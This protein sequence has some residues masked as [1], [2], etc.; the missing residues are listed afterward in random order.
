MSRLISTLL[1]SITALQT[2]AAANLQPATP[3]AASASAADTIDGG[4]LY[5]QR[6]A[7]CHDQPRDRIPPRITLSVY[8]TPEEIVDSLSAGT[9][10]QQAAGLAAHEIRA[11][12]VYLTGKEPMA[13]SPGPALNLCRDG[14]DASIP[15]HPRPH[16]WN[17]WGRDP[18]NTRYHPSSGLS[19]RDVPRLRLKWA[20]AYPGRAAYGQPVVVGDRLFGGGSGGRVFSLD[21]R[22]GCTHWS[23]SAG[24]VV[25]TAVVVARLP[26]ESS[27][28]VAWFGDEKATLH[29]VD[30]AT[31]QRLWTTRVTD[32]PGARVLS[33]PQFH[34][35]R[36]YVGASSNEEVAAADANYECCT[37]RGVVAA[38]DAASGQV[39]WKSHTVRE[40]PQPTRRNPAGTQMHGPAG[41]SIFSSPTID[42]K[43]RLLY[44]GTGNGYTNERSDS[45]NAVIA[46]DLDTGERRW[47][48]QVRQNDAWILGCEGAP[49]G[50]C[51]SPLGVDFGFASSPVLATLARGRQVIVAAEK[52]GIVHGLD[53]RNRGKILWQTQLVPGSPDGGILWGSA[54]DTRHVYVATSGYS[55]PSGSGPGSLTALETATGRVLWSHPAPVLGCAWGADRC[56]QGQVAAVTAIPGVVFS[57]ALDGHLRAYASR[58]GK[59]L[60]QF[61]T[62]QAFP[63]VNGGIAQGGG[64]DY[65]GQTVANGTLYVHSGSP[66]TRSG[67]ALLAF[68]VDGR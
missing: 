64:I 13:A 20:F 24:A 17:G 46:F 50:N 58:D 61:D 34:E 15:M 41:G 8:R 28:L 38:L 49:T 43:R 53:P 57:G 14:G 6:C 16:D 37:F 59:V 5:A 40:T 56:A 2:A 9:M 51:P 1:I 22:T 25:R 4:A 68:S 30:A 67:N 66:R 27:R 19:A 45:T 52:S 12:A 32:H 26:A 3:M 7:T 31:G 29:A 10:R 23:Y 11:L 33:T 60:W 65:G 44:V 18:A 21:A 35:G 48:A 63:A 36:L 62:G 47:T 54:A 42:T 39:I 55:Y